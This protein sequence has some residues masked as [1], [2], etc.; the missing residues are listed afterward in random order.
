MTSA[1]LQ[2]YVQGTLGLYNR[3]QSHLDLRVHCEYR[4]L[5]LWLDIKKFLQSQAYSLFPLNPTKEPNMLLSREQIAA[6]TVS[7]SQA[8]MHWK[9][10][11]C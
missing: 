2:K 9:T 8:A 1:L 6:K 7:D 4:C 3:Q 10:K 11:P 5:L